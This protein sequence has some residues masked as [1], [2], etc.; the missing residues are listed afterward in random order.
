MLTQVH[1]AGSCRSWSRARAGRWLG[2]LML[3][4]VAACE[5]STSAVDP[6]TPLTAEP[7]QHM[8]LVAQVMTSSSAPVTDAIVSISPARSPTVMSSVY[9]IEAP[10]V[11][12]SGAYT[13]MVRRSAGGAVTPLDTISATIHARTTTGTYST[14]TLLRFAPLDRAPPS[15]E[16]KITVGIE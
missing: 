11:D 4:T 7:V 8:V 10:D 5:S 13:F 3:C 15:V 14:P 9:F 12:S 2:S 1:L 6:T 16:V